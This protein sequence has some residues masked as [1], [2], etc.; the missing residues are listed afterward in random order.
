MMPMRKAGTLRTSL[1]TNC[2]AV[3]SQSMSISP[4]CL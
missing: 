3:T 2:A 4:W 1:T